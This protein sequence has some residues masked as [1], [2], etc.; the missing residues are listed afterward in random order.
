MARDVKVVLSGNIEKFLLFHALNERYGDGN[1]VIILANRLFP[2]PDAEEISFSYT[3]NA[4]EKG[5]EGIKAFQ[6]TPSP[7]LNKRLKK[8]EGDLGHKVR[9]Q[10]MR[11]VMTDTGFH[12][13]D[14]RRGGLTPL[15]LAET[16][17]NHSRFADVQHLMRPDIPWPGPQLKPLILAKNGIEHLMK[18]LIAVCDE[19]GTVPG[20]KDHATVLESIP[21]YKIRNKLDKN[22]NIDE[23]N[24]NTFISREISKTTNMALHREHVT[25]AQTTDDFLGFTDV[26]TPKSHMSEGDYMDRLLS[27]DPLSQALT[28]T[29]KSSTHVST[30]PAKKRSSASLVFETAPQGMGPET[31]D[32]LDHFQVST[33][34]QA[35]KKYSS[36]S[37]LANHAFSG[38]REGFIFSSD[39]HLSGE[40]KTQ[41]F[42]LTQFMFTSL[43]VDKQ[44]ETAPVLNAPIALYSE[45][46]N[47]APHCAQ[48]LYN[49]GQKLGFI[50]Q[51]SRFMAMMNTSPYEISEHLKYYR[52]LRQPLP[53]HDNI[54]RNTQTGDAWKYTPSNIKTLCVLGSASTENVASLNKLD[55][56]L[57][58]A[59]NKSEEAGLHFR[60]TFGGGEKG[61]MGQTGKTIK[62]MQA[63]GRFIPI[64]GVQAVPVMAIEGRCPTLNDEELLVYDDI[65]QRMD[66]LYEDSD[67]FLFEGGGAGTLQEFFGMYMLAREN[68]ELEKKSFIFRNDELYSNGTVARA[69]DTLRDVLKAYPELWKEMQ[70]HVVFTESEIETNDA[71][72]DALGAGTPG[73]PTRIT[74][75]P[76]RKLVLH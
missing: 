71:V 41:N 19:V 72:L 25:G 46:T 33:K 64:Q 5:I 20:I 58:L 3:D 39:A 40:E 48:Q 60:V 65:Y 15:E 50:G 34:P 75:S 54:P 4:W 49:S 9:L 67:V 29:L 43:M 10:N 37:E 11:F 13:T 45:R 68:N 73:F 62:A 12:I 27:E 47:D 28:E 61:V 76:A 26:D 69:Y 63:E 22:P 18:D 24:F 8:L 66:R 38:Q 44:M 30:N 52:P 35:L 36:L 31:K 74:P 16:L 21:L 6:N 7:E 23:L 51:R 2:V 57:R 17:Y 32:H 1:E 53:A 70:E 55:K 14:K 59:A 42:L 56:T